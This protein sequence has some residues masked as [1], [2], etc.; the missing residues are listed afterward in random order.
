MK[1][2]AGLGAF[3]FYSGAG[4]GLSF[5]Q[6]QPSYQVGIVPA[7]LSEVTYSIGTVPPYYEPIPFTTP[8]RVIPDVAMDAD[9]YT[10]FLIGETFTKSST[11]VANTGCTSTSST[12][13]YCL[14]SE[15][16]TSLAS[17]L[18]AGVLALT[19]Q[20]R[21]L[22]GKAMLGYANPYLYKLKVGGV[23][24]GGD[25]ACRCAGA[26]VAH[27]GAA[28]LSSG[29]WRESASGD[30]EFDPEPRLHRRHLRGCER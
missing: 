24:D 8:R 18:L 11:A 10:G 21:G 23:D 27:R 14:F 12:E 15:G 16:G 1:A 20:Q 26:D 7:S 13:E 9:P 28:R 25:T 22:K 29:S 5:S 17:P 3:S 19:D 6:A 2:S 4:G 30:D